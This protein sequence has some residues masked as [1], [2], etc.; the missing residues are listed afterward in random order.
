M[1]AVLWRGLPPHVR[2]HA[3]SIVLGAAYFTA[4][5]LAT[6]AFGTN[7]PIWFA[8]ALAVAVLLEYQSSGGP[9]RSGWFGS[10][11]LRRSG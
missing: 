2:S 4:A 9:I 1:P 8:N 3:T 5:F 6:K 10:A 7:T 11:M